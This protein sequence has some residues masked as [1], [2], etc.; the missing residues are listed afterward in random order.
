M[1]TETDAPRTPLSIDDKD[2]NSLDRL[3]QA[4][5][6]SDGSMDVMFG[7]GV[8][9]VG[10]TW[11]VDLVVVGAAIPAMLVPLWVILHRRVVLPRTGYAEPTE[12]N[13]RTEK[14]S[15]G[16]AIVLGIIVFVQLTMAW[17]GRGLFD[18][19]PESVIEIFLP[20]L[21]AALVALFA[22]VGGLITKQ[23]SALAYAQALA[24]VAIVGGMNALEPGTIL[25]IAGGLILIMAGRKFSA[26]LSSHPLPEDD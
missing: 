7:L 24:G 2:I 11:M 25:T 13:L 8:L 23:K 21:P 5:R 18:A 6:F 4:R 10:L 14:A 15:L 22:L 12:E 26:F 17:F 9:L 16:M 20:G 19:I 3:V 1:R